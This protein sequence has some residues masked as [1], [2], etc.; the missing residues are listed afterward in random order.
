MTTQLKTIP[1]T[2]PSTVRATRKGT[3]DPADT[4]ADQF[5]A[6]LASLCLAS[7]PQPQAMPAAKLQET[8]MADGIV[9]PEILVCDST[10]VP[11]APVINLQTTA[12]ETGEA[13]EGLPTV[14]SLPQANTEPAPVSLLQIPATPTPKQETASHSF[15]SQIEAI[16]VTGTTL[17]P[18]VNGATAPTG[19]IGPMQPAIE[20]AEIRLRPAEGLDAPS[21]QV[22]AD[23]NLNEQT[24]QVEAARRDANLVAGYL[25]QSTRIDRENGAAGLKTLVAGNGFDLRGDDGERDLHFESR[26]HFSALGGEVSFAATVR[27]LQSDGHATSIQ[28]QT[29]SEIMAQAETLSEGQM[30]SFRL[31]LK[32]PELGQIDIQVTRDAHGRISAHISAERET[33]RGAL[34]RSLDQLRETLSRAGLNVDK[35]QISA[36]PGLLGNRGNDD[37]RSNTREP[38]SMVA[39]LTPATD[40]ESGAQA[41]AVTERLLSLRA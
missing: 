41:P 35:L 5:A 17:A 37:A 29:I 30:R 19:L 20:I 22:I 2:A 7:Q 28:T 32:P 26:I 25:A 23:N 18:A 39:N 10:L 6:M 11:P 14:L 15:T 36:D 1:T 21:L 9:D 40:T 31:R 24:L 3:K 4:G 16:R 38:S 34:F 13:P 27:D 33:A 8:P 12:I